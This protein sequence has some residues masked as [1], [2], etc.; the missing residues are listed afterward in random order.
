MDQITPVTQS[1]LEAEAVKSR[2]VAHNNARAY[3]LL[4]RIQ[5]QY[6]A[7]TVVA[8]VPKNGVA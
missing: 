6:Q 1:S 5:S 3:E 2:M 4:L 7:N 8:I